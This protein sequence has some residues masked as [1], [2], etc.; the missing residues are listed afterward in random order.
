M[1]MDV[2]DMSAFP[3]GSFD[4]IIDKGTF[5]IYLLIT[6]ITL[7]F[8]NNNL[9]THCIHELTITHSF[10]YCLHE[11]T[12]VTLNLFQLSVVAKKTLLLAKRV[13]SNKKSTCDMHVLIFT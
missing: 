10:A 11:L 2:R 12:I 6:L 4:A 1:K 3:T 13:K 5:F 8:L 9:F 7:N